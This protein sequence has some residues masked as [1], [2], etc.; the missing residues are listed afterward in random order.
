MLVGN[1]TIVVF[2]PFTSSFV[3]KFVAST[4]KLADY[5][6]KSFLRVNKG[7]LRTFKFPDNGE[8]LSVFCSFHV[9]ASD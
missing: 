8:R 2:I 3:V 7:I 5:E 9:G 6:R 1:R 4:G